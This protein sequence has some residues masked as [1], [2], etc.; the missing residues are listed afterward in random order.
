M[1]IIIINK[2]QTIRIV[3]HNPFIAGA[4]RHPSSSLHTWARSFLG[5]CFRVETSRW[6]ALSGRWC[7]TWGCPPP[8][9]TSGEEKWAVSYSCWGRDGV[10]SFVPSHSR[11]LIAV[12]FPERT[13]WCSRGIEF[14]HCKPS[15]RDTQP[16]PRVRCRSWWS[17]L[18]P[19]TRHP[20]VSSYKPR[21]V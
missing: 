8:S 2:G 14:W 4:A 17:N 15:S 12:P 5:V 3:S 16:T 11:H 1:K 19:R 13:C 7:E 21:L 6:W 10:E 18:V 20:N 9:Q